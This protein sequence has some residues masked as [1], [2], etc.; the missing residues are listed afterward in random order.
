MELYSVIYHRKLDEIRNVLFGLYNKR[1]N[2]L[3]IAEKD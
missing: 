1:M 3:S 2:L